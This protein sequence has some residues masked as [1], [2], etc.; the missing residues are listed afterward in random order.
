MLPIA[1]FFHFAKSEI[2]TIG[3]ELFFTCQIV[4]GV[5]K[6]QNLPSRIWQTFEDAL[7]MFPRDLTCTLIHKIKTFYHLVVPLHP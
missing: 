3:E 7:P 1:F 6:S 4:L 2:A 5:G